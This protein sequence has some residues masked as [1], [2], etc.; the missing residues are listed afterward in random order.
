MTKAGLAERA[1]CTIALVRLR[2]FRRLVCRAGDPVMCAERSER[3]GPT[4]ATRSNARAETPIVR[5]CERET[6]LRVVGTRLRRST[7]GVA[8]I[9][10]TGSQISGARGTLRERRSGHAPP[11]A[12]TTARLD[13][14]Q[15]LQRTRGN[16]LA[17]S[18]NGERQQRQKANECMRTKKPS[19]E[20]STQG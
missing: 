16:N 8:G 18:R 20:H 3:T 12:R 2:A 19:E 10:A 15:R 6:Q 13:A 14:V 1:L 4:Q 9:T 7:L 17:S 11:A 5:E